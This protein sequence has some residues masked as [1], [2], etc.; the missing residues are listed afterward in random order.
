MAHPKIQFQ[1]TSTSQFVPLRQGDCTPLIALTDPG[2]GS[3]QIEMLD[4]N[5]QQTTGPIPCHQ[6]TLKIPKTHAANLQF[7]VIDAHGSTDVYTLNGIALKE[8]ALKARAAHDGKAFPSVKIDFD[9]STGASTLTLKANNG[10]PKKLYD[11]RV[12]VQCDDGELGLIDPKIV[13]Q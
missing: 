7:S 11:F 3:N 9:P 2:S 8:L 5:G 4:A 6:A 1:F 12:L 13:N 10:G